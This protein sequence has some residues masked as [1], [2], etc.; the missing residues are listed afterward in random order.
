MDAATGLEL[1]KQRLQLLFAGRHNRQPYRGKPPL[2]AIVNIDMFFFDSRRVTF[3][4]RD[5]E[6]FKIRSGISNHLDAV[7]AGKLYFRRFCSLMLLT[8]DPLH[9]TGLKQLDE[10][11]LDGIP[12]ALEEAAFLY[13]IQCDYRSAQH[14]FA[15]QCNADAA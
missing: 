15:I 12:D 7:L 9:Q 3:R 11:Q 6:S 2:A 14:F 10:K 5:H 4:Y 1:V 13:R 8:S